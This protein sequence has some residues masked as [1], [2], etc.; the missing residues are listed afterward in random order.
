MDRVVEL[1]QE[2][3]DEPPSRTPADRAR[4][5]D[6][7]AAAYAA[8]PEAFDD[9]DGTSA[10]ERDARIDAARGVGSVLEV[11]LIEAFTQRVA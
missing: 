5:R 6:L 9:L 1:L 11:A 2:L 8:D 7:I 4:R 10:A 3:V